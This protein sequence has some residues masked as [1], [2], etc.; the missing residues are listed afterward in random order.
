MKGFRRERSGK[1]AGILEGLTKT[2]K[3]KSKELV[4]R[5]EFKPR[6]S[7]QRVCFTCS[8]RHNTVQDDKFRHVCVCH[9]QF[10]LKWKCALSTKWGHAVTQWLRHYATSRKVAGSRPD[11][12][13][14][15]FSIPLILVAALGPGVYSAS[16]GNEYQKQK[17]VSGE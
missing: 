10:W 17:N 12:V 2:T 13:N 4:H 15:F 5:P 16:N 14:A 11:E 1:I 7:H 3:N 8:P 6:T 9:L